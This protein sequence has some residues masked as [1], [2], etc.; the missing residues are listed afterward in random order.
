MKLSLDPKL[1]EDVRSQLR[2]GFSPSA[3][4]SRLLRDDLDRA[5][6]PDAALREPLRR[7]ER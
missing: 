1:I 5:A 3:H 6:E 2:D 4:V 7:P